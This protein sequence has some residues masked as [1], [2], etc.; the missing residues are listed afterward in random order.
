MNFNIFH[1]LVNSCKL[2]EFVQIYNSFGLSRIII[3]IQITLTL[4][5]K[6]I[7]L[8][9]IAS[10]EKRAQARTI[11]PSKFSILLTNLDKSVTFNVI[12]NFFNNTINDI[13]NTNNDSKDNGILNY[14]Y[15]FRAN[16]YKFKLIKRKHSNKD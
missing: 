7:F 2:D 5:F 8:D 10:L 11:S 13:L 16:F 15:K 4:I 12:E 1:C 3:F 9:K 6:Y 14:I